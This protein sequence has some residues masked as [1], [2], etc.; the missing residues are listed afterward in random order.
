MNAL[1]PKGQ[2]TF[3]RLAADGSVINDWP[4]P[5]LNM[6]ANVVCKPCNEGWMSDIEQHHAAPAMTDL[7]LGNPVGR[8]GKTRADN[9]ALF[10]F[11][12]AV[13]GNQM[14]P[15][16]EEFFDKHTRQLFRDSH[17]IPPN[18]IMWLFGCENSISGGFRNHNVTFKEDAGL[19]INVCT[20]RVAQF[21]FQVVSAKRNSSFPLEVESVPTHPDLTAFF[22]P[23]LDADISWPRRVVLAIEGFNDFHM[24][25]NRVKLR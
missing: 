17:T 7:I 6:T 14:L 4:A 3:Q 23:R 11:K 5:N 25:W 20:F 16:E 24:R 9:I 2:I 18:V 10:A 8:I 12:T 19:T 21:G 22:Y 15:K 1:F 13:L